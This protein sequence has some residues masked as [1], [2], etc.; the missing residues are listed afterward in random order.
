MFVSEVPALQEFWYPVARSDAVGDAPRHFRL[1]GDDYVVWR[2]G[3][4]ADVHAAVD[5][6][7]HRAGRLSQGWIEDG[8]LV[9]PYHGWRFD[10]TGRCVEIPQKEPDLPVPP[11]ARVKS[12]LAEERYGL[13]WA[14]VGMPRAHVPDLPEAEAPGW[15]LIHEIFDVWSAS[16][17][18]LIDNA[19]DVSHL[20]FVHK[21]TIGDPKHPKLS[22]F[23]VERDGYR[24][25]FTVSY[26]SRV[27]EI[28]RRNVGITTE[29]T[30][31]TTHAE[32]VQPFVF[33]GL[34]EYENG[35]KHV[36]YRTATPVD[37]RTS[38]V[39]QFVARN[40]DPDPDRQVS[41]AE[42]DRMV[43]NED[44]QIL[45]R[46]DPDFPID[47]NAEFHTR[48]DRMTVE[49]RRV[50]ADLAQETSLLR[51]E[52]RRWSMTREEA[53]RGPIGDAGAGLAR[54]EAGAEARG[55]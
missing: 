21:G 44:R 48:A 47:L 52:D 42:L 15:T 20:S 31:R 33:R 25:R 8:A 39:C 18:R 13:V 30:T 29:H 50:L 1:F 9:C 35:I 24:L 2:P 54:P 26:T 38:I 34:L 46:I 32:L 3:P 23:R 36:L 41:I 22:D 14:C 40:D 55:D 17:T 7:P 16:A 11:R 27:P 12:V 28:Q 19:L 45:E 53:A 49:Y 51:R 6:C 10:G 37:D 43:Q 4:D 5:E